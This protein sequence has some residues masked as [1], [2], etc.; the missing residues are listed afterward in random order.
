MSLGQILTGKYVVAL[1]VPFVL[2]LSGAVAKKIVRGSGWK[3]QDFF[4]G[5]QFTLAAMSSSLIYGLELL[6]Q[7]APGAQPSTSATGEKLTLAW[8]FVALTYF[9]LFIVLATHQDYEQ[10]D[11]KPGRQ[12]F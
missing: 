6:K 11:D 9:L 1:L 5:V 12:F 8:V 7:T 3:R 4:L 10:R 2:L